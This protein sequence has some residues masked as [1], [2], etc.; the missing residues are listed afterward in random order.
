MGFIITLGYLL[1][2]GNTDIPA[3]AGNGWED[4]GLDEC[5]EWLG[6]LAAAEGGASS[7]A[8]RRDVPFSWGPSCVLTLRS[9]QQWRNHPVLA[10][11]PCLHIHH[12]YVQ[13]TNLHCICRLLGITEI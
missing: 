12:G 7:L 5:S 2:P 8:A 13:P 6:A 4:G 9:G 11:I 3:E 1:Q 10:F